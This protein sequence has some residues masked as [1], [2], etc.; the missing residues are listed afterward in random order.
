MKHVDNK[1]FRPRKKMKKRR[2]KIVTRRYRVCR[3]VVASHSHVAFLTNSLW[4]LGEGVKLLEASYVCE[5]QKIRML[6]MCYT[7]QP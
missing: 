7:F 3:C 6:T 5:C 1:V 4:N 2:E